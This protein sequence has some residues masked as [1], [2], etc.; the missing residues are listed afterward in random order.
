V[1]GRGVSCRTVL[2]A[3]LVLRTGVVGLCLCLAGIAGRRKVVVLMGAV[4]VDAAA[5]D[6]V[7]AM[8]DAVVA[9]DTPRGAAVGLT[10]DALCVSR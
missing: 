6:A 4:A 8:V 1:E 9:M 7:V 2:V 10:L 5:V 3:A